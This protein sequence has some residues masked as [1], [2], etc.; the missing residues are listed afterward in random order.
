MNNNKLSF[1]R[2]CRLYSKAESPK[3]RSSNAGP[4][5]HRF[6]ACDDYNVINLYISIDLFKNKL[7]FFIL[8]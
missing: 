3:A 8:Y 6:R 7:P 5:M 1:I 4:V 2:Y